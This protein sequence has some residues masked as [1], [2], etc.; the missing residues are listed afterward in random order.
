MTE[1]VKIENQPEN[2]PQPQPEQ[3]P[4]KGAKAWAAVKEWCR[5]RVVALKVKPQII[6][7][8]ILVITS[9]T[10][11]LALHSVG[12][13]IN[14]SFSAAETKATGICSFITTLLSL[15][16]L[17][18]FLNAFPKRK[19]PNIF[20]IVLVFVMIAGIVACDVV[21]YVQMSNFMKAK[22]DLSAEV[23][24][25]QPYIMAHLIMLGISALS[26]ALLPLYA[27]LIRKINTSIKLE[28][29]TEHMSGNIDIEEDD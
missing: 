25:A 15:L 22:P 29:A 28:S 2:Q 21:Y 27:K 12:I 7:L 6:P 4:S 17:V 23:E 24:P 16:V 1:E 5:K 8:V 19:K 10:F 9:V 18:S 26:F 11:M 20:F 14:A 3:T 13:A